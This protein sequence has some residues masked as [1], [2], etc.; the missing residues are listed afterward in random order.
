MYL[1]SLPY[2]SA[3]QAI[4]ACQEGERAICLD[5]MNLVI[6][7]DSADAMAAEGIEFAY[8]G[9]ANRADGQRVI[10]TVPVN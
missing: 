8:L 10:V 2:R 7:R 1:A 6:D 9:V 5:G 4:D 3:R